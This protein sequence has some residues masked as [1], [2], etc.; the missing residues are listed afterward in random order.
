MTSWPSFYHVALVLTLQ[1]YLYCFLRFAGE[2][3]LGVAPLD[4]DS[5]LGR[6]AGVV[7]LRNSCSVIDQIK[8]GMAT[9]VQRTELFN[10]NSLA[11]VKP[12]LTF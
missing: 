6:Q 2:P 7:C 4:E 12:G 9:K 10:T 1:V 3:D 8:S 5:L 11:R